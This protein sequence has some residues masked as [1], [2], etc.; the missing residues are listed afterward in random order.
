MHTNTHLKGLDQNGRLDRHMQRASDAGALEGLC[1]TILGPDGHETGHFNLREKD[2][3]APKV[4]KRD[5]GDLRFVCHLF[6]VLQRTEEGSEMT[7]AVR[8]HE[9]CVGGKEF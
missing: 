3:L 7:S 6:L 2:F 4:R 9:V 8:G 1:G 5:V